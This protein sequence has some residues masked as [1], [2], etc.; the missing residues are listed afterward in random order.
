MSNFIVNFNREEKIIREID[1]FRGA[2]F[3]WLFVSKGTCVRV[4]R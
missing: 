4:V 2:L 1:F 3:F